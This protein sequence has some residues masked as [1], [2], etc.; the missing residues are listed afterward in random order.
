MLLMILVIL[1]VIYFCDFAMRSFP[2]LI[3]YTFFFLSVRQ[4]AAI[5]HVYTRLLIYWDASYSLLSH[6]MA[7]RMKR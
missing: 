2:A 7:V 4:L 3:Q 5:V 6:Q 1:I